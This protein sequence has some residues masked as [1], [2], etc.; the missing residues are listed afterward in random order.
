MID[1]PGAQLA[2]EL[3][4]AAYV[5]GISSVILLDGKSSQSTLA[6]LLTVNLLPFIGLP[7]YYFAGYERRR[8]HLV[9][10][11][12]E[13]VM[14][15]FQLS[16]ADPAP[17]NQD[18]HSQLL[19]SCCGTRL[20]SGNR[21]LLFEGGQEA[22]DALCADLAAAQNH[23][24]IEMFI[25]RMDELGQRIAA[26]LA[27]RARAGVEVRLLVDR[28]GCFGKLPRRDRKAL[29]AAGVE[30]YYFMGPLNPVSSWVSNYLNHRKIM[31]ID[32]TT[33][34]IGGLNLGMEY[35]TGGRRFASWRDIGLRIDGAACGYLQAIF[36]TD[37]YNT[38]RHT[39][40]EAR[41]FPPPE[42]AGRGEAEVQIGCSGP[43]SDWDS[44]K[45][46][47]VSLIQSARSR[48]WI[49]SPYFIPDESALAA[50][51]IAAMAGVDVQVM[52]TGVPDKRMPFW[53]ANTFFQELL[54]AGV[55]IYQYQA[56]FLHS[57]LV[58]SDDEALSLGSC[59]FDMRSFELD[60]EVN[61]LF[62]DKA[63][64][65]ELSQRFVT[66]REQCRRIT[67]EDLKRMPTWMRLRNELV[68]LFTPLL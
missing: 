27:E 34:Y 13:D 24:H 55:S 44:L 31:L 40:R 52:M 61:G 45:L 37:W 62:Y 9:R 39:L 22:F 26:I 47:Y 10:Q 16:R 43:D 7:I 56:G 28:I 19:T 54:D 67:G 21:C 53:A 12:P 65:A 49:Q 48:L 46:L 58:L 36:V 20:T 4:Y 18:R 32:G 8:H 41:Y 23:I 2:L 35:I 6:W 15:D 50:L 25:L 57:K 42:P 66:D 38:T 17:E 33:A 29:R 63:L 14:K 51:K 59:N 68:Q 11:R 5:L 3:L 60:Y 30:F 64:S 1:I